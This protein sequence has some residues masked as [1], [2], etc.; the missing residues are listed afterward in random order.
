MPFGAGLR[1]S[2]ELRGA[3]SHTEIGRGDSL[4]EVLT[5]HLLAVEENFEGELVTSILLLSPD[6]KHLYHGAGPSLPQA[7][8]EAING[9]EIGPVAGSCGTAAFLRRPVYVHDISSDP[10]WASYRDL[11]LPHGLRACWSTPIFDPS[12]SIL[13][14]FAIYRRVIGTPTQDEIDSIA[15][16]TGTVARAIMVARGYQDLEPGFEPESGKSSELGAIPGDRPSESIDRLIAKL[17]RLDDLAAELDRLALRADSTESKKSL[18]TAA[19]ET[20]R[21]IDAIRESIRTFRDSEA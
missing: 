21:S 5:R 4:S 8:R 11:A 9:A 7:Y 10:L 1:E 17:Q 14:T 13:G 18:E 12:G 3:R 20:R 19:G 2:L 16:I 15:L 6:A